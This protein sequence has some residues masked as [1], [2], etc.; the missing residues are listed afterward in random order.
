MRGVRG[1]KG[2]GV[3]RTVEGWVGRV[4]VAREN[5]FTI[6]YIISNNFF[7]TRNPVT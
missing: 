7:Q 2:G 4:E 3:G 5:N 6:S 1:E